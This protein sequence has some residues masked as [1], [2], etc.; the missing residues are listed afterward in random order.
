MEPPEGVERGRERGRPRTRWERV[1]DSIRNIKLIRMLEKS[2]TGKRTSMRME[3]TVR[4]PF[5]LPYPH[6]HQN[7]RDARTEPAVYLAIVKDTNDEIMKIKIGK[8][9]ERGDQMG[10]VICSDPDCDPDQVNYNREATFQQINLEKPNEVV[11][12]DGHRLVDSIV[13]FL[14][15][16]KEQE[17]NS[18]S[19]T[20]RAA[21][22]KT[23][24]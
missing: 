24:A 6:S 21:S 12:P 7:E 18:V 23:R 17:E 11:V 20:V 13:V 8:G 15:Q 3:H 14:P 1:K 19:T 9:D 4:T 5:S 10:R 16:D 22:H 2:P